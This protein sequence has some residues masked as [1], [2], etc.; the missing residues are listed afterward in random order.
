M[1][2][3][4]CPRC[5]SPRQPGSQVCGNCAFDYGKAAEEVASNTGAPPTGQPASIA[6]ETPAS[7]GE[8][9]RWS[10]RRIAL[11]VAVVGGLLMLAVIGFVVGAPGT[12]AESPQAAATASASGTPTT[13]TPTSSPTPTPT[14]TPAASPAVHVGFQYADILRVEVN[15]LAVRDAPLLS[16][17]VVAGYRWDF[18]A[19]GL[20]EPVAEVRL[21]AGNTVIVELGPLP[22]GDT[23]WYQVSSVGHV[24]PSTGGEPAFDYAWA[25]ASWVAASVGDDQYLTLSQRLDPHDFALEPFGPDGPRVFTISGTGDY[26]S[27][28]QPRYDLFTLRWAVALDSHPEPCAFSVSLVPENGPEAEVVVE[29]STSDVKQGPRS[30]P[31]SIRDLPWGQSAGGPWDSFNVSIRSGCT[32]TLTLVPLHPQI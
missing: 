4:L 30:G 14:S 5:G 6:P 13:A 25:G 3:D 19:G 10:G 7:P 15:G 20:Q 11:V 1:P 17:S 23:V 26:E 22:I 8:G 28:P 31:N 9:P 2:A 18:R 27:G 32:W 12:A 24:E 29:T 16:S 21:G